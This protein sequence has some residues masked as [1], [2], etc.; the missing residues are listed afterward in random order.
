MSKVTLG[1]LFSAIALVILGTGLGLP[2][3]SGGTGVLIV[4]SLVYA[5]HVSQREVLLLT[6][7]MEVRDDERKAKIAPGPRIPLEAPELRSRALS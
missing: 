7:S 6:R 3:F 5:F 4:A 1:I 2:T